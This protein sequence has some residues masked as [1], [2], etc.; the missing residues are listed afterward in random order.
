M[1]GVLAT[2]KK[3]TWGA[4]LWYGCPDAALCSPD[5]GCQI[6]QPAW[7]HQ[8]C[9]SHPGAAC[10]AFNG[11]GADLHDKLDGAWR[12]AQL[13]DVGYVSLLDGVQGS[14]GIVQDGHRNSQLSLALVLDLACDISLQAQQL[15]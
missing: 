8:L 6:L 1:K 11:A 3:P 14:Q 12:V 9:C 13:A 4:G 7:H 2:A 5:A 10:R 15:R